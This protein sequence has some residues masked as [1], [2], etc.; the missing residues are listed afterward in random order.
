MEPVSFADN[1][2]APV[3]EQPKILEPPPRPQSAVNSAFSWSISSIMPP[4]TGDSSIDSAAESAVN[5]M[6]F[7]FDGDDEQ[8]ID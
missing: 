7:E 2:P 3:H 4:E 6:D 5:S 8:Y 1:I